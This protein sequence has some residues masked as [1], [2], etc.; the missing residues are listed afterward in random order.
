MKKVEAE[1][2][3]NSSPGVLY[4]RLSTASGLAEWFADNVT[5]DMEGLYHFSWDDG[6]EEIA[7]L[8]SKKNG[9]FVKFHWTH[10]DDGTYLEFRLKTDP[11]T[12]DLALMITYFVEEGEEDES[13]LLWDNQIEDLLHILGS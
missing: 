1:Y 2:V 8:L 12:R 13:R 11:I 7:K 9:E 10:M 6:E 5:I 4:N 3:V